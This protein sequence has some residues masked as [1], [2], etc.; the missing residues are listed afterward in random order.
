MRDL[1]DDIVM[2]AAPLAASEDVLIHY[3]VRAGDVEVNGSRAQLIRALHNVVANAIQAVEEGRGEVRVVCREA[4]DD[5]AVELV[6]E[7][8][9][10]GM[11]PEVQQRMFEPYFT[12]KQDRNGTGLGMAITKRIVEEHQG[13][14]LID[15]TPGRGTR[16]TIRLPLVEQQVCVAQTA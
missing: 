4:A 11:S 15:S 14:L 3:D 10:C 9:G 7:D 1:V 2:G 16:V 5:D 6:V 8:N 13:R 12:T